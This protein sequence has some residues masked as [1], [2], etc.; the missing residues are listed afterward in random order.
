[1]SDPLSS[2]CVAKDWRSEWQDAR[3]EVPLARAAWP[4]AR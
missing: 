1:M 4:N 3:F 2:K